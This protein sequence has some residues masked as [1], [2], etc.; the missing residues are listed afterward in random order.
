MRDL[1]ADEEYVY[2]ATGSTVER[3]PQE[4]MANAS[5]LLNTGKK[6]QNHK[7]DVADSGDFV[8]L[9]GG[10]PTEGYVFRVPKAG[11]APEDLYIETAGVGGV[12]LLRVTESR[13]FWTARSVSPPFTYGLFGST[14]DGAGDVAY[15]LESSDNIPAIGANAAYVFFM[16]QD[17]VG[18]IRRRPVAS[19]TAV[20]VLTGLQ[21]CYSIVATEDRLYAACQDFDFIGSLHASDLDGSNHEVLLSEGEADF[22]VGRSLAYVDGRLVWWDLDEGVS[23]LRDIDVDG[24]VP[25]TLYSTDVAIVNNRLAIDSDAYFFAEDASIRMLAR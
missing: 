14:L 25:R 11:G 23:Y 5:V 21:N 24:G 7:R 6:Y 8:M 2:F 17:D 4:A 15:V 18:R 9:G 3:I 16:L 22:V 12:Q 20:D 1:A 19:G 13:A 10:S